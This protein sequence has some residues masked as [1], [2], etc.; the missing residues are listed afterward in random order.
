MKFLLK[1]MLCQQSERIQIGEIITVLQSKCKIY[2]RP[3]SRDFFVLKL[4]L[5]NSK[6]VQTIL[7]FDKS[8]AIEVTI[9]SWRFAVF[10]LQKDSSYLLLVAASRR[11]SGHSMEVAS[12]YSQ[13]KWELK[14]AFSNWRQVFSALKNTSTKHYRL[15]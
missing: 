5:F 12:T 10:L 2:K 14:N 1:G 6:V 11:F 13:M 4:P 3:H 9:G 7:S 15:D 8:E